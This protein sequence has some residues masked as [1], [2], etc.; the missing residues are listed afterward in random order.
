[1]FETMGEEDKDEALLRPDER[2]SHGWRR[3][4]S[5]A[6]AGCVN[7]KGR[8]RAGLRIPS[9]VV[10]RG[11]RRVRGDGFIVAARTSASRD[12]SRTRL[13]FGYCFF[14]Q[15]KKSSSVVEGDVESS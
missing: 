6:E 2:R 8:V 5:C 13:S 11:Y 4:G 15:A 10:E 9:K 12:G 7:A 14:G 3:L 1:M